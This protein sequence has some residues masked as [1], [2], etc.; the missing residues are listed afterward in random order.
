M[1]AIRSYY[2][3][4]VLAH[5]DDPLTPLVEAV[6]QRDDAVVFDGGLQ[7]EILLHVAAG[8]QATEVAVAAIG[9]H[10]ADGT[11]FALRI[12]SYN[13]CYTKLLRRLPRSRSWASATD[14]I[15]LLILIS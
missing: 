6:G 11:L 8:K 15:K 5:K 7:I 4:D 2:G 12:T 13:V 3:V 9:G 14:M 10:Q 1:Y